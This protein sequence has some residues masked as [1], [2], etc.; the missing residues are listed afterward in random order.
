MDGGFEGRVYASQNNEQTAA[1]CE[2]PV[3][4]DPIPELEDPGF[5]PTYTNHLLD[6]IK[7]DK[8]NDILQL[9]TLPKSEPTSDDDSSMSQTSRKKEP[10][11][12]ID[13]DETEDVRFVLCTSC[14]CLCQTG[15][16]RSGRSAFVLQ[17]GVLC[18]IIHIYVM[19]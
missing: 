17:I 18:T 16:S 7:D 6:V 5:L 14:T 3:D 8:E 10:Q 1:E 15:L 13:D 19:Q 9:D 11:S 2:D 4:I 12:A